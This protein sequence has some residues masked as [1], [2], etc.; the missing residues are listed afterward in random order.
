M[1]FLGREE[2]L[3]VREE[4]CVL[5]ELGEEDTTVQE[6]FLQEVTASTPTLPGYP[7]ILKLHIP[8]G[9]IELASSKHLMNIPGFHACAPLT[10]TIYNEQE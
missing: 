6:L 10:S 8:H 4:R 5:G 9:A 3:G 7:H 1:L 2:R